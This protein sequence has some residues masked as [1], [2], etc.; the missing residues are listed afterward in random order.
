MAGGL[1]DLWPYPE[2]PMWGMCMEHIAILRGT[3]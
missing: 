1:C 2:Y 3:A